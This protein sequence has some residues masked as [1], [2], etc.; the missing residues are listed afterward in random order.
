MATDNALKLLVKKR[1]IVKSKLTLFEKYLNGFYLL[2]YL[3][4]LWSPLKLLNL[5]SWEIGLIDFQI[6]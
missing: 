5:L 4:E 2:D 1:G 6:F 3:L